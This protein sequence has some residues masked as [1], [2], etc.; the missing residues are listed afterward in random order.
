MN[1]RN[2]LQSS[3]GML[4][5]M[6]LAFLL[7]PSISRAQTC[8]VSEGFSA[9]GSRTFKEVFEY[10]FVDVKPQYPGGNEALMSFINKTRQY[11][12]EAYEKGIEGRVTCSFV[13]NPDGN[14]SHLKVIK[15]SH[16][17]LNIEAMRILAEMPNWIPGRHGDKCVPV[18]VIHSIPFRK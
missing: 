18:R 12:A 10:D 2:S 4:M 11:P 16:K 15:G 14:I 13:V 1:V 3:S 5:L 7:I 6:M 8:R 17:S 9:D